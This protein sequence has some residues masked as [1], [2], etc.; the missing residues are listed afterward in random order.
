MHP[1]PFSK[2]CQTS[3]P[4]PRKRELRP[5]KQGSGAIAQGGINGSDSMAHQSIVQSTMFHDRAEV[6][7]WVA[8][9]AIGPVCPSS[10]FIPFPNGGSHGVFESMPGRGPS[11]QEGN[12]LPSD[13]SLQ[14]PCGSGDYSDCFNAGAFTAGPYSMLTTEATLG[15]CN[16]PSSD[17]AYDAPGAADMVYTTSSS[18]NFLMDELYRDVGA[19]ESFNSVPQNA[20]DLHHA[21]PGAPLWSSPSSASLEH[22][23]SSSYTQGSLFTWN[24]SS[25]TSLA[26]EDSSSNA[27]IQDEAC[28]PPSVMEY[29]TSATFARG[30]NDMPFDANRFV[31]A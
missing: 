13:V 19:M 2:T 6:Q 29:P 14:L 27:S 24:G 15:T 26:T 28:L 10:S 31:C 11:L 17:L 21:V 25:P 4:L 12:S 16:S 1:S 30:L 9:S 20:M 5:S 23:L 7:Q 8:S 3:V 18:S 22:S